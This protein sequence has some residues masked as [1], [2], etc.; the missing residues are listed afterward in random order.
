MTVKPL[1]KVSQLQAVMWQGSMRK[2]K[3]RER[4]RLEISSLHSV[5]S[6]QVTYLVFTLSLVQLYVPLFLSCGAKANTCAL[7]TLSHT[8]FSSSLS[9]SPQISLHLHKSTNSK[10]KINTRNLI[11]KIHKMKSKNFQG[12]I[13]NP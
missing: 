2:G 3:E 5:L 10:W 13:R 9:L 1:L 8:F 11:E 12:R 6:H 7:H 4:E